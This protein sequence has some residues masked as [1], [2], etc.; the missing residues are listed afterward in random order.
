MQVKTHYSKQ[1]TLVTNIACQTYV[2][3]NFHQV[4]IKGIFINCTHNKVVQNLK[5]KI[6]K[7]NYDF[8]LTL[9]D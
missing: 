9:N 4:N 2:C 1:K 6:V 7:N 8:C 5:N 3:L